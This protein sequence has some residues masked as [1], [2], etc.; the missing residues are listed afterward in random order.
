TSTSIEAERL[1]LA[2][3][4]QPNSE[5]LGLEPLGVKQE[6]GFI[7]IDQWC[8]TNVAGL[9]AIGDL[10]GGPCLAHKASHEALLCVDHLAGIEGAAPLDRLLVPSCTYAR[11]QVASV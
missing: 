3:G 11:P 4:V 10:A 9:Y 7:T 8:R 1:L 5:G 6:S 2:I